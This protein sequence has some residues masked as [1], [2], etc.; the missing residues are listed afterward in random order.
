MIFN[1]TIIEILIFFAGV[2]AFLITERRFA[3]DFRQRLKLFSVMF[4]VV[5][6]GLLILVYILGSLAHLLTS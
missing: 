3:F 6:V 5:F 1:R 4:S 2:V